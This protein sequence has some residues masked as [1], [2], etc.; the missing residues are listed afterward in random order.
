MERS[1]GP[2]TAT[3]IDRGP[4]TRSIRS[5]KAQ[6]LFPVSVAGAVRPL[7]SFGGL[8]KCQGQNTPFLLSSRSSEVNSRPC[9]LGTTHA[10]YVEGLSDQVAAVQ[11]SI[12]QAKALLGVSSTHHP[13]AEEPAILRASDKTTG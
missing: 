12:N 4:Q 5:S 13:D 1:Q 10:P 7:R 2:A 6:P 9:S 3:A 8:P 11:W